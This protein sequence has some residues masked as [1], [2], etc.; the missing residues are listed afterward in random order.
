MEPRSKISYYPY[1]SAEE[2]SQIMPR[3]NFVAHSGVVWAVVH[4]LDGHRIITCSGDGSL[5]VWNLESEKQIG[6]ELRD[7]KGAVD[8]SVVSRWDTS[9]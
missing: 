8:Y 3:G 1:A 9:G 7:G 5:R 4:L 2:V 6:D